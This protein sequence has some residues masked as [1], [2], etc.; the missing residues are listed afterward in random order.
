M[1]ISIGDRIT[2]EDLKIEH[3]Y[4]MLKWGKHE[5]PLF[6]DYN[7]PDLNQREI[8]EWFEAKTGKKSKKCYGILNG[9]GEV[10]GYLTIKDIRKIRKS[11]VLGI[12][13]D[14][15]H[16]NQGYGTETILVFLKYFFNK[17]KMK[18][19]YLD[20]ARFNKRAIRCY[21]KCGF[22]II[23]EYKEKWDNY[24]IDIFTDLTIEEAKHFTLER[25]RLYGY[26]YRMKINKK[27]FKM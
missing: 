8:V 14:P 1:Y 2:I 10:I 11:A 12:V 13:F 3:V 4:G 16:L 20:V 25:G 27:D 5:S 18:T 17:L 6:D 22:G 26:F 24:D 23:S 21:E 7:F 15:N 9:E 19:M